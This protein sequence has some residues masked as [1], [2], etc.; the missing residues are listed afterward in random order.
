[1]DIAINNA[2]DLKFEIERL[3]QSKTEQEM[4]IKQ[5]FDSPRAILG[6][7][8]SLF[9]KH[10]PG[11]A[12]E[13]YDIGGMLSK[14]LL[15]F[16]LNKTLFRKSGFMVKALVGFLS[17][18]ASGL[19]NDKTAGPLWDKIRSLIPQS[20]IPKAT[21]KKPSSFFSFLSPKPSKDQKKLKAS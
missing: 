1:M 8:A 17:R 11:H 3:R 9:F 13:G 10:Q 14:F 19:V 5:H 15:P 20:L 12:G 18:K 4:V 16:T 21:L 2:A 7:I 6:T